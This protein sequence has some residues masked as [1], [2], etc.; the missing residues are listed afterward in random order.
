MIIGS[1]T[2]VLAGVSF[3]FFLMFFGQ[4]TDLFTVKDDAVHKGF[5]IFI[6]FMVIGSV[7]WILSKFNLIKLLYLYI[8]GVIQALLKA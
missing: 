5:E 2:S 4:I 3:P 6:K 7:Y 8:H 1:I